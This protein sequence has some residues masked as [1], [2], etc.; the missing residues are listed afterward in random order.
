MISLL[1]ALAAVQQAPADPVGDAAR[2]FSGCIQ[3][4]VQGIPATL[5]PEAGADE[6][7][8][9]CKAELDALDK[10]VETVIAA[11]PAD[12][13]AGARESYKAGMAGGR[14]GLIAA[15]KSLREA[16]PK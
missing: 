6:V 14:D 12:Q 3:G 16:K 1:L 7:I 13:Q 5:T 4:K 15:I 11:A 8:K 9:Q 2:A 10:A